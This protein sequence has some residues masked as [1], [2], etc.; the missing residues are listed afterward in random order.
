[1]RRWGPG[2]AA[3]LVLGLFW[4]VWPT[5]RAGSLLPYPPDAAWQGLPRPSPPAM[6]RWLAREGAVRSPWSLR[7][8]WKVAG[9]D[10]SIRPGQI[11]WDGGEWPWEIAARLT[12][13][14][15][16]TVL[17]TLPEG[18]S[19]VAAARLL[20]SHFLDLPAAMGECVDLVLPLSPDWAYADT[21]RLDLAGWGA[22]CTS[23]EC[24]SRGDIAHY[25]L[26]LT[27]VFR[28]PMAARQK[29]ILA[30]LAQAGT[31]DSLGLGHEAVLAIAGLV[32]SEVALDSE[33]P[34]IAGVIMNR[35]ALGMPLQIDASALYC[36]ELAGRPRPTRVLYEH[37]RE[38][39]PHNTY[40]HAG[41][42]P[43][44]VA[45]PGRASLAAALAPEESGFLYYV[46]DGDGPGHLFAAD[47]NAHNRNIQISRSKRSP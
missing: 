29:E 44:P 19:T 26:W 7:L 2:L 38:D 23:G 45:L 25:R 8:V 13:R 1:M 27:A 3:A 42:P 30:R 41:L 14:R 17:V 35:L 40:L 32:E 34:R 24:P 12:A 4:L 22:P 33:R 37:L 11:S 20:C 9:G 6:A 5:G 39:C 15:P 28:D 16:E 36:L 43:G 21:Y 47:I 18:M 46:L 31:A 10:R